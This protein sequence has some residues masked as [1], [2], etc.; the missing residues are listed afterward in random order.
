MTAR[1]RNVLL[2][3]TAEPLAD[4]GVLLGGGYGGGTGSGADPLRIDPPTDASASPARSADPAEVQRVV[5]G[6][7]RVSERE[8]EMTQTAGSST[9]GPGSASPRVQSPS[10]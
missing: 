1:E 10:S 4:G 9:P 5:A 8:V 6:I 7:R 2:T 3:L